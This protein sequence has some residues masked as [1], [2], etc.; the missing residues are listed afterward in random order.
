M[1]D[2]CRV[3]LYIAAGSWISATISGEPTRLTFGITAL[4]MIVVAVQFYRR[5]LRRNSG[6]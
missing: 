4:A 3:A 6:E 1:D 2:A 5:P